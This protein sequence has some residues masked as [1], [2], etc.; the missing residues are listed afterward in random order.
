[1]SHRLPPLVGGR[2]GWALGGPV[3]PAPARPPPLPLPPGLARRQ[4]VAAGLR[5][6]L[7]NLM[8]ACNSC[9][10]GSGPYCRCGG[11][12]GA[13]DEPLYTA[14]CYCLCAVQEAELALFAVAEASSA[15]EG[16][17]HWSCRHA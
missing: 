14:D 2:R 1:M 12:A 6:Q 17:Q 7:P 11:A 13:A 3:S 10:T 15:G 5:S 4:G 9:R 16:S 8:L